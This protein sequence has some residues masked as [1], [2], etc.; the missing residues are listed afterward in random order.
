MW[1]M[2]RPRFRLSR[3]TIHLKWLSLWHVQHLTQQNICRFFS[4]WVGFWFSLFYFWWRCTTLAACGSVQRVRQCG[5]S[6]TRCWR[7]SKTVS[8][9]AGFE[10]AQHHSKATPQEILHHWPR[11]GVA[12][13]PNSREVA[14]RS[15]R[16]STLGWSWKSCLRWSNTTSRRRWLQRAHHLG[17]DGSQALAMLSKFSTACQW[18]RAFAAWALWE[19]RPNAMAHFGRHAAPERV[20]WRHGQDPITW[21]AWSPKSATWAWCNYII[22]RARGKPSLAET[23]YRQV[24]RS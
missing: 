3:W 12:T 2:W 11:H 7:S 17:F 16:T 13:C 10:Q 23:N 9:Q 20:H 18:D 5:Q 22:R 15:H 1:S 8:C 24:H 4:T 6:S 14:P 21:G 19:E